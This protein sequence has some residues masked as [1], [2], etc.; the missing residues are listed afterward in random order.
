MIDVP[1]P[2]PVTMPDAEPMVATPVLLLVHVP[3]P[4]VLLSV[5]IVPAQIP[6]APV[7]AAAPVLMVTMVVAV[8]PVPKE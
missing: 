7:I 1:A 3:P 2:I 8:Q 6:V 4:V 5:V